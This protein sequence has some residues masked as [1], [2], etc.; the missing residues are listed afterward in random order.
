MLT[1]MRYMGVK[2]VVIDLFSKEIDFK[3]AGKKGEN[4]SILA[5]NGILVPRGYI[6]GPSNFQDHI[7]SHK[8]KIS[9]IIQEK[10]LQ[11]AYLLIRD[12]IMGSGESI[13]LEGSVRT[14]MSRFDNNAYFV[15]RS[16]GSG[17]YNGKIIEED[18][19]QTALAGQF[20]SYLMIPKDKI[21]EG[22]K[23]CWASLFN[24]RSLK[25]FDAKNNFTYLDSQMS[26]VVQE[27]IVADKGLVMMTL[28]PIEDEP[29]LGIEATYGSCETLVSGRDT[30]DLYLYRKNTGD[31]EEELSNKK[32]RAKYVPFSS[33]S[34]NCC[35]EDL[36]DKLK[37]LSVLT[38]KDLEEVI[39]IGLKIEKIFGRPQDIEAVYGGDQLYI[40]QARNITTNN[41]K[42]GTNI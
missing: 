6:V 12:I 4:L 14:L 42:G 1:E 8:P 7:A 13:D 19:A 2:M 27:M 30:G 38:R 16:S 3:I 34:E 32:F 23:M 22:I 41:M 26:V 15:A 31:L 18:S 35:Y 24:P 39:E 10:N 21:V 33:M 37:R 36:P 40:T 11:E 25:V 29:T 5:N 17:S 20:D 28:D 9:E